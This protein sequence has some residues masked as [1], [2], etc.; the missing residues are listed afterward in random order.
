MTFAQRHLVNDSFIYYIQITEIL[1]HIDEIK[2]IFQKVLLSLASEKYQ[3]CYFT[4]EKY[5]NFW[6]TSDF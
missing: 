4:S 3:K 1:E 6:M 5:N 2:C